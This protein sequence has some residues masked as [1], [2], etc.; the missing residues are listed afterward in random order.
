MIAHLHPV[1]P[2]EGRISST[3]APIDRDLIRCVASGDDEAIG[4][5]VDRWSGP[6]FAFTDAMRVYGREADNI[7]EEVFRRLAFDAPR[8][9]ARPERF[10]E[11][12]QRT[13]RECAASVLAKTSLLASDATPARK[14]TRQV[15]PVAPPSAVVVRFR[16]LLEEGRLA[17]ALG[18]LNAETPFRFTGVYRFD[19][20]TLTNLFLYDR[21]NGFGSDGTVARL[22]DTYCLWIHET[23]SVVQMIDSSVDPRAMGHSKRELV[24]SYCGGPI[25]DDDGNLFGTICH[26]D[27]VPHVGS[28]CDAL[29]IL[30][31]VGPLLARA[32]VN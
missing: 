17:D 9:V 28:S 32:I 23:L 5:M 2:P 3:L 18:C 11:W 26:F 13:V 25:R 29:P 8:F 20:L 10:G 30:A 7:I 12:I 14:A 22:A 27:F 4:T 24:R 31:E 1:A 15:T 21:E 16:S 19:G 6:L